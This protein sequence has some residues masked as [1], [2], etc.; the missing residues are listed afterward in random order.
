MDPKELLN[1]SLLS[2]AVSE[3]VD[4]LRHEENNTKR[5]MHFKMILAKQLFP[6]RIGLTLEQFDEVIGYDI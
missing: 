3:V 4:P 1:F 6:D 2:K 5:T